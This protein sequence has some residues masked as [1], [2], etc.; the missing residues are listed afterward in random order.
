ME[1]RNPYKLTLLF[2]PAI[3]IILLTANTFRQNPYQSYK[4]E[5]VTDI[6]PIAPFSENK[7]YFSWK[8]EPVFLLGAAN[9]HSWTPISR[10]EN[11][12]IKKQMDRLA[13]VMEEINSPHVRG[14][15]RCLPYDPNNHM[16]DGHVPVVL[17]PWQKT[18]DGRYDLTRMNP[19]W[20]KRLNRYLKL[21]L[22]RDIIV[23]LE[24]WDDWSVT[25][26]PGGQYD[27][28]PNAGWNAHPFNPGN[29]VNYDE[30]I[31]PDTTSACGAPFYSTIPSAGNIKSVL[32]LQ[33][34]Y[35]DELMAIADDYP[36][37][38][39]NISNESRANLDW[40]RYWAE[41]IR[42][43]LPGTYMIGDMPSTNR[44][45]GGG[46][47][48]DKF[49]PLT[50]SMDPA[51]DYAD[52]SQGVSGH[53]FNT[54]TGQVIKGAER[55]HSYRQSMQSEGEEKPLVV[56]KDYTR[57]EQGGRMVLWSRFM[58]GAASAR[59]HRPSGDHGP[60]VVDFQHDAVKN[61]GKFIATI[62]FWKMSPAPEKIRSLPENASANVL[63]LAKSHIV[64]QLINGSKGEEILLDMEPGD[65]NYQWIQPENYGKTSASALEVKKGDTIIKI[66]GNKKHQILHLHT[67]N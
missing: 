8:G 53:E 32:R 62:P 20:G 61:L 64:V 5:N 31:L 66:P 39:I 52:I 63:A 4:Q 17:Q 30:S 38:I 15:V 14:F 9:F 18:E 16:H 1:S 55:I 50:L 67:G 11:V 28:G 3:T 21:A 36:N 54:I 60:E 27:P 37:V 22:E 48:Q 7:F 57:D 56:S 49:S 42:K 47:C 6:Q 65:W 58:G 35:V 25:R 29:N 26:G 13:K 46:Q 19:L 40:S 10:P 51:Y 34:N 12:D 41:Y 33:K 43:K 45:D 24:V 2:V 23:S 44:K 59:F